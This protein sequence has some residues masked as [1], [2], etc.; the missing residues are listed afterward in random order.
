MYA[1][2]LVLWTVGTKNKAS[3]VL[4][5]QLNKAMAKL[6]SWCENKN[7]IVNTNKT[8]YQTFSLC[9]KPLQ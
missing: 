8:V 1:D 3:Q 7:M 6:H 9:H 2:D 4:E 5:N